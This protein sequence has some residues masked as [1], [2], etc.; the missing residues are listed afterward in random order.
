MTVSR[1]P[2]FLLLLFAVPATLG[3]AADP[4]DIPNRTP[5]LTPVAKP[6]QRGP[7]WPLVEEDMRA[8]ILT[9]YHDKLPE[10]PLTED[11]APPTIQS[12]KPKWRK[13]QTR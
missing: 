1:L 7:L 9:R 6:E 3:D 13:W 4:V 11:G 5:R 2:L 12:C 10:Q 8:T